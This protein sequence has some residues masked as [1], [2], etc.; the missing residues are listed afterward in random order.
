VKWILLPETPQ[1]SAVVLELKKIRAK[2]RFEACAILASHNALF[3]IMRMFEVLA[4][5]L[6]RV[7]RTFRIAAE[8]EACLVSQQ[9]LAEHKP[10]DGS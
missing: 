2:V 8:A 6:F 4:E 7:T 3:G 5:E 9:S 10:E 1:V